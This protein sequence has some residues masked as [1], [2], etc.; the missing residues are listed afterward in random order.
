VHKCQEAK[1][2]QKLRSL[3]EKARFSF[4]KMKKLFYGFDFCPQNIFI[5]TL[6]TSFCFI[7][8]PCARLI[9]LLIK[10]LKKNVPTKKTAKKG[11]SNFSFF[12]G[13]SQTLFYNFFYQN[14]SIRKLFH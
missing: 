8:H 14:F 3:F 10:P 4:K 12:G 9:K 7:S 2:T 5:F 13:D 1:K 11:L 6:L